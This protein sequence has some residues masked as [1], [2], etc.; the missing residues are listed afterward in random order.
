VLGIVVAAKRRA[1]WGI[2]I[3]GLSVATT[4]F[5]YDRLVAEDEGT[6]EDATVADNVEAS[7]EGNDDGTSATEYDC[8]YLADEAVRIS[9][10]NTQVV[11]LLKVRDPSIVQDNRASYEVPTG[12]KDTLILRCEGLGVYNDGEDA[13]TRLDWTVDS[14]G[15]QYVLFKPLNR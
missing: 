3:L 1:A 12:T 7:N 5:M 15:D 9:A 11:L 4:G 2:V 8:D 10:E 6:S 13:P 14:D